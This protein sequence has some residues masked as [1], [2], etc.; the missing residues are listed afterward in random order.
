M[1]ELSKKI[2]SLEECL[3]AAGGTKSMIVREG[4][5]DEIPRILKSFY[6]DNGKRNCLIACFADKNTFA[7]AGN[8]VQKILREAGI[9][10][11]LSHIFEDGI[12]AD[13]HH[14]ETIKPLLKNTAEKIKR[15]QG[16]KAVLVPLAVGAGTI[17]DL[18]KRAADET[19]LPYLCI[20]TAASVDGYTAYGAA[21]LYEGFKQTMSCA[22]PLAVIADSAVLAAAPSYL[23]S[24]GFGDLAGKIIAGTDWIISDTVFNIDGKGELAPGSD[25]IETTA[26]SMVQNPLKNNLASSANAAK[27]DKDAV[28]ILFEALGITGFA[29]QY[30][31]DSRAV[32]GCEH[33][34]SHVWEMENLCVAGVPVTH[35]HKVAM[36]TLAGAAFTECLFKEKPTLLKTVPSWPEQEALIN[37][38][39]AELKNILPSVVETS[40]EKFIDNAEKLFKLR[41]GILDNWETLKKDVFEKLPPYKELRSQLFEAGCPVIPE[42]I[43]LTRD[44]VISAA[45]KAQM[46]R[47]RFTVLDMAFNLGVFDTI[48]KKMET[49]E[50][51]K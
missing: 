3:Q 42:A 32:S 47:K 20:P 5:F 2:P 36:G 19:S 39:F 41:E 23:N 21:L 40:K 33:M 26:W 43:N 48:L 8:D 22:A 49:G 29:L 37:K 7:A 1:K 51:F 24:S 16:D 6:G 30:M 13:Y 15:E 46:I 35:G 31:K 34:W 38:I 28:K 14:V 18:V 45:K 25:A 12:H 10:I 44:R 11:V 9:E 50:Y 17:N 4:A 27:G